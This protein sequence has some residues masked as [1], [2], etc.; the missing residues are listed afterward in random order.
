[1]SDGRAEWPRAPSG[2]NR[3]EK[4]E[5]EEH[6]GGKLEHQRK[7]RIVPRKLDRE[8][9]AVAQVQRV[10]RTPRPEQGHDRCVAPPAAEEQGERNGCRRACKHERL[11]QSFQVACRPAPRHKINAGV[12]GDVRKQRRG[13]GLQEGRL[14]HP[15]RTTT[16]RTSSSATTWSRPTVCP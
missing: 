11:G 15:L 2:A 16:V 3:R 12:E 1:M 9:I 4:K 13:G 8:D 5:D 10:P 7:E 6:A 14:P